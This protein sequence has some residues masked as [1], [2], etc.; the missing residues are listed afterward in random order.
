MLSTPMCPTAIG[1]TMDCLRA[2]GGNHGD[3]PRARAPIAAY[4]A[5]GV[6]TDLSTVGPGASKAGTT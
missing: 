6:R 3:A 2:G 4:A 1:R 5:A